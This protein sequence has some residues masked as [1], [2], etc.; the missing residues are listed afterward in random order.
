MTLLDAQVYEVQVGLRAIKRCSACEQWRP[1]A[2]FGSFGE[3]R[4]Q[5]CRM[6]LTDAELEGWWAIQRARVGVA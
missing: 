5:T 6:P 3:P 1:V 2:E 4:C